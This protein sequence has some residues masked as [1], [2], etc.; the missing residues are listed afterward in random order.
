MGTF[1]DRVRIQFWLNN[2]QYAQRTVFFVPRVGDEIRLSD[3]KIYIIK[4]VVWIY[5]EEDH[6]HSRVNVEIEEI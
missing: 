3:H 4:R 2:K 5:D 1:K 6:D